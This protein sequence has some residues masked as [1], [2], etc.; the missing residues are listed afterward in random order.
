MTNHPHAQYKNTVILSASDKDARR[1]ATSTLRTKFN[2]TT[3]AANASGALFAA[4]CYLFSSSRL[5]ITDY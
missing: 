4:I 3:L 2:R 5:L 1:T